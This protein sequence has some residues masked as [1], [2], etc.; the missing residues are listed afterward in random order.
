MVPL[1]HAF[2]VNL[3]K[4]H[5]AFGSFRL[6]SHSARLRGGRIPKSDISDMQMEL[7]GFPIKSKMVQDMH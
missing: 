3:Q 7:L 1:P 5:F 4:A 6:I 2:I